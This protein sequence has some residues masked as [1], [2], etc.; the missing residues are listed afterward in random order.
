MTALIY[1]MIALNMRLSIDLGGN[2]SIFRS[3]SGAIIQM[4]GAVPLLEYGEPELPIKPIFVSIPQGYSI[5]S[6][7]VLSADSVRIEVDWDDLL[8]NRSE[9]FSDD[10]GKNSL[11]SRY[12]SN[13]VELLNTWTSFGFRI[14]V[15][16]VYPVRHNESTGETF[17]VNRIDVELNLVPTSYETP[18]VMRRSD[19][20]YVKRILGTLVVNPYDLDVNSPSL[21]LV[22]KVDITSNIYPY[23]II[24]RDELAP[25]FDELMAIFAME[26][27]PSIVRSISWIESHYTGSDR[28]ERVR[29]FIRDMYLHHGT[30][31]VLLGADSPFL[32]SR[33]VN[34][35][36]GTG[37][38]DDVPTDLYFS[39]LDGTWDRNGNGQ[40][41]EL[42]DTVDLMPDVFVGRVTFQDSAEI[43]NVVRKYLAYVSPSDTN[44]SATSMF[45]GA[46]LFSSG[47]GA[48]LCEELASYVPSDFNIV[49]MYETNSHDNTLSDFMNAVNNGVG[50]VT[51]EVHGWYTFINL[52]STPRISFTYN[53]ADTLANI[54]RP[55]VF[56][57]VSCETGGF[58]RECIV[59]HMM[60]APGGAIAV[61]SSTRNN[62][63]YV[64]QPYNIMFFQRLYRNNIRE[65][66]ALDLMSRSVFVAY[67]GAYNH[68]RYALFSYNL[69][70]MPQLRLWSSVPSRTHFVNVPPFLST[71]LQDITVTLVD[72]NGDPLPGKVVSVY[73][74]GE[75]YGIDTTDA[76]GRASFTISPLTPGPLYIGSFDPTITAVV[77]TVVVTSGAGVPFLASYDVTYPS[78]VSAGDSVELS[79]SIGNDGVASFSDIVVQAEDVD[80]AIELLVDSLL[81]DSLPRM[82]T[83]DV[84]EPLVLRVHRGVT[85]GYVASIPVVF[86]RGGEIL[87]V[88]TIGLEV[89]APQITLIRKRIEHHVG[90]QIYKL[91]P[92]IS[93][94][95]NGIARHVSVQLLGADNIALIDS[96]AKVGDIEPFSEA[97]PEN[98]LKFMLYGPTPDLTLTIRVQAD[99]IMGYQD[100]HVT[101]SEIAR[102]E[103]LDVSTNISGIKLGWRPVDDG[104]LRGYIVYRAL[105]SHEFSPI[106]SY[107]LE[108]P[109]FVDVNVEYGHTYRYFVVAVDTFGTESPTS[110]TVEGFYYQELSGWPV[111]VMGPS[112]PLIADIDPYPGKEV[113]LGSEDGKVYAFHADG[114]PVDGWPV[115]IGGTV[116]T[117]PAAGDLDGD[118]YD[119]VVVIPGNRHSYLYALNG[120]G[121]SVDG[122]PK[123]IC[124]QSW[125]APTLYDLDGDGHLEVIVHST[126]GKLYA[127]RSNGSPYLSDTS[128]VFYDLPE[129]S[130]G[131]A[132]VAVADINNDGTPE[133]VT[134]DRYD[135]IIAITYYGQ[136]LSGFPVN[137]TQTRTEIAVADFVPSEP[138]LEIATYVGRNTIYMVTADGRIVSG[139]PVAIGDTNAN[140]YNFSMHVIAADIDNDSVPEVVSNA[141]DGILAYNGDGTPVQGFPYRF[142]EYMYTEQSPVAADVDGDGSTEGFM[143]SYY[144]VYGVASD[145]TDY[146]SFP[147]DVVSGSH[148]TPAIDDIDGDGA[149]EM[150]IPA[151]DGFV[152]V[153]KLP[154]SWHFN[155][156]PQ[157]QHDKQKTGTYGFEPRRINSCHEALPS[158][159]TELRGVTATVNRAE[160]IFR[161]SVRSG[162]RVSVRIFS[163]D[164]RLIDEINSVARD[165]SVSLKWNAA[166]VHSGVYF[167]R[168]AADGVVKT[169]KFV[170]VK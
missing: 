16:N 167:Y 20:E 62:Y 79:L 82:D 126:C 12:R 91:W 141:S 153:I 25:Y 109:E 160:V 128:G 112:A 140:F 33:V 137:G 165:K 120:D 83:I 7:E 26:G 86:K 68:S 94:Y 105:N 53:N 118:G 9:E 143:I 74:T 110:D 57:I 107:P 63:P 152:H 78:V 129:P 73:K 102:P 90:S 87:S 48:A 127:F 29:N 157:Y 133:V 38:Y 123:N 159:E 119:E 59:E 70:G 106:T 45:V 27:Y 22:D 124:G 150:V 93:N 163:V 18:T 154:G 98:P 148:K 71:G 114:T 158:R 75:T 58:D 117:S 1:A 121:T 81:I 76:S 97:V 99:N 14:G 32:P 42:E 55:A 4:D 146:G 155:G 169:G 13:I 43:A 66:A 166:G 122:W 164:G 72:N 147:F 89:T 65:I 37:Y 3:D 21:R 170:V 28:L 19:F 50:L 41:A 95:G 84:E 10:H 54:D 85:D 8:R 131:F 104:G 17:L 135:G 145:G 138:G 46:D 51:M 113:I 11:S 31:W 161:A 92:V 15:L 149:A 56:N 80:T 134:G 5:G 52:N 168:M 139:W 36:I 101:F 156:W 2:F 60:R 23:V 151:S 39:C 61:L 47:D 132:E 115:D 6:V 69:M 111:V 77:E 162:S 67:S 49:R 64:V 24:T 30:V 96:S 103:S 142:R 40:Y 35:P 116:I 44:Y 100:F 88:D 108:H 136:A 34:I 130:S 125:A 144:K